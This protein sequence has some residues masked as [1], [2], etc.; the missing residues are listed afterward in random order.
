MG[1]FVYAGSSE[2]GRIM[3]DR[4]IE[5][6]TEALMVIQS[7]DPPGIGARD[8][9]ECLLLQM[10]TLDEPY[11]FE[12]RLIQNHMED[13]QRNKLPKIVKETGETMGR[14]KTAITVIADL[15]R[16]RR[17][18]PSSALRRAVLSLARASC[19]RCWS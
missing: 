6:A 15:M 13:I 16:E 2:R 9:R 7:L 10:D 12:R 19:C 11:A 3:I 8:L 17:Y 18:S 14:I 4:A 5:Q 1:T